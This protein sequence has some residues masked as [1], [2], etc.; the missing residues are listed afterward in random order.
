MLKRK[1]LKVSS[2]GNTGGYTGKGLELKGPGVGRA[3]PI[4]PSPSGSRNAGGPGNPMAQPE[5]RMAQQGL[6][7]WGNGRALASKVGKGPSDTS[8]EDKILP[9]A[10]EHTGHRWVP[11]PQPSSLSDTCPEGHRRP[12]QALEIRQKDRESKSAAPQAPSPPQ[13][14]NS[15]HRDRMKQGPLS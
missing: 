6:P 3:A 9:C 14:V 2:P 13:P 1:A 7:C 12:H 4:G 15:S 10:I 5:A 11:C 8:V